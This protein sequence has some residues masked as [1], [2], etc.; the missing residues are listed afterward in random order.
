MQNILNFEGLYISQNQAESHQYFR[1]YPPPE[2][3]V[4]WVVST[5]SPLQVARWL[6][7]LN[8]DMS[9]GNYNIKKNQ[10]NITIKENVGVQ[11]THFHA[12]LENDKLFVKEQKKSS[13]IDP[14]SINFQFIPIPD[15]DHYYITTLKEKIRNNVELEEFDESERVVFY[16]KKYHDELIDW[17]QKYQN[18]IAQQVID[19]I[20]RVT[21][22]KSKEF[23][24]LL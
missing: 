14:P 17:C 2:N 12:T 23:N 3:W 18:P 8:L 9:Y 10:I 7:I 24:L 15:I 21:S 16:L 11:N 19:K 20:S 5:G 4:F 22:I 6:N 1:F 13:S